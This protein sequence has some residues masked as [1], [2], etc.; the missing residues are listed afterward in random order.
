MT[1][2]SADS[3]VPQ[4]QGVNQQE[5]VTVFLDGAPG[6]ALAGIAK[7]ALQETRQIIGHLEVGDFGGTPNMRGRAD[8]LGRVKAEHPERYERRSLGWWLAVLPAQ[9][10]TVTRAKITLPVFG[11]SEPQRSSAR[12]AE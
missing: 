3:I 10:A 7:G 11:R 2:D 1:L 9:M 8:S 4:R 5:P 12:E 6:P